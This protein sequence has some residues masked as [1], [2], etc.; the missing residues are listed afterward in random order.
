MDP[1]GAI[2]SFLWNFGDSSDPANKTDPNPVHTFLQ[3]GPLNYNVT[4][5]VR[6]N[7]GAVTETSVLVRIVPPLH[8]EAQDVTLVGETGAWVG[9]DVVSITDRDRRPMAG[10]TVKAQHRGPTSGIVTGVTGADGRVTLESPPAQVTAVPW[11]FEVIDVQKSGCIY[12]AA[13]N[14]V[15]EQCQTSTV[16]VG[17][18]VS[19][20]MLA[21]RVSPNPTRGECAIELALPAAQD[22]TVLVLDLSGR[23]VRQLHS[24]SLSAGLNVLKWDGRDDQGRAARA[25]VYFVTAKV[26]ERRI[27]TR[28]LRMN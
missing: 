24:A 6:D 17:D 3:T 1:D 21:L 22:V 15:T 9:R 4:L 16:A 18:P 5:Q 13:S 28:A 11:C 10:V 7:Q 2:A 12:V 20:D 26:G 14:T 23:R 8:V 25:G 27:T 19:P